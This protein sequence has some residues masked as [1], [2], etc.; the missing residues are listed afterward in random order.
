MAMGIMSGGD[1]RAIGAI[2]GGADGDQVRLVRLY[3]ENLAHIGAAFGADGLDH[4]RQMMQQRVAS[5]FPSDAVIAWSDSCCL[6]VMVIE[7][8]VSEQAVQEELRRLLERLAMPCDASDPTL[9][10]M[11]LGVAG[12]ACRVSLPA[13]GADATSDIAHARARLDAGVRPPIAPPPSSI[14]AWVVA[15]REDMRR[16][17]ALLRA[18]HRGELRLA[19]QPIIQVVD[20]GFLYQ[21]ALLRRVDPVGAAEAGDESVGRGIEALERIGLIRLLDAWVVRQALAALEVHPGLVL[22]CNISASSAILDIWWT[23]ILSV[24]EQRPDL[25]ARL[26]IEI[27]ETSPFP[28]I[29]RAVVFAGRLRRLGCRLAIDDFG[30][31]RA[32]LR[33]VMT[34]AP[35]IVKLDAVFLQRAMTN[36]GASRT[37]RELRHLIALGSCGG[38]SVVVEGVET[39]MMRDVA[40]RAGAL[41]LQGFEIALPAVSGPYGEWT[42]GQAKGVGGFARSRSDGLASFGQA[43]RE[44]HPIRRGII[45]SLHAPTATM[46]TGS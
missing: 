37:F 14:A 12:V 33:D 39:P 17:A 15:Y 3:G 21:E 10:E 19:W 40:I 4:V 7:Q 13:D 9:D 25:A 36:D 8:A 31:G 43:R 22:G 23:D 28:C 46:G 18:L 38:R 2:R 16:G 30:A 11:L 41:F 29:D 24:L 32:S 34:L 42:Q 45:G 44:G 27:T 20:N 5:A 35:D 26:V 6:D 1:G